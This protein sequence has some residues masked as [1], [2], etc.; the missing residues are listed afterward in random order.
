M[1]HA[2]KRPAYLRRAFL[3][4]Y[5]VKG[6]EIK[7]KLKVKGQGSIQVNT[8]TPKSYPWTGVYLGGI[9]ITLEARPDESSSFSHWSTPELR[10]DSKIEVNLMDDVEIEA[11]FE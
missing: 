8:I 4:F 5:K 7:V 3:N 10:Q 6:R 9:P 1:E 11:I 2:A